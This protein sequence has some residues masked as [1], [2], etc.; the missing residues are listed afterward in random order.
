MLLQDPNLSVWLYAQPVDMRKQ[1]DGLAALAQSKLNSVASSGELFVFV[2]RRRT[3]IK[4]LYYSHGG[5]CLWSKRLEQGQFH[6]VKN[7]G[8][9]IPLNWAQL[10]CLIEGIN[11]QKSAISKRF[12]EHDLL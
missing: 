6:R 1:F 3:Q 8:D 9:K 12:K 5:Y 4:I 11:W 10:Q 2:N 7:E